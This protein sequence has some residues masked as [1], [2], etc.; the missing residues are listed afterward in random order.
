[1][2]DHWPGDDDGWRTNVM[3]GPHGSGKSF[4]EDW[5]E[6]GWGMRLVFALIV[7]AFG[8]GVL[9]VLVKIGWPLVKAAGTIIALLFFGQGWQ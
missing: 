8:L 6:W 5:G 7:A 9:W 2:I 3:E 4:R 1:M